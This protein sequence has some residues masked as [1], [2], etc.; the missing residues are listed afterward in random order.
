[1]PVIALTVDVLAT[2]CGAA[3]PQKA[4]GPPHATIQTS[5]AGTP[6]AYRGAE[7]RRPVARH[8]GRRRPLAG[9]RPPADRRLPPDPRLCGLRPGGRAVAA[10][11]VSGAR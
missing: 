4:S 3:S 5:T 10:I 1:M 11:A 9:H 8:G 2:G 7:R 6:H